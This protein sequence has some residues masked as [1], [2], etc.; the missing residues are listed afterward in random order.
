MDE[1]EK[2]YL[3]F[4]VH[5]HMKGLFKNFLLMLEEITDR[6]QITE[7]DFEFYRKRVLDNGNEHI[8]NLSEEIDKFN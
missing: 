6:G 8:R 3:R 4:K 2:D 1:K 5:Q 7:Q